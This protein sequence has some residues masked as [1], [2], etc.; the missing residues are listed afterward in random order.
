L[1]GIHFG[2]CPCILHATNRSNLGRPL[3]AVSPELRV[4]ARAHGKGKI[5]GK[6]P[7][8]S[9][10]GFVSEFSERQVSDF[11]FRRIGPA[12][13][14]GKT[15]ADVKA[16]VTKPADGLPGI[17][18]AIEDT[19]NIQPEFPV[20]TVRRKNDARGAREDIDAGVRRL[21]HSAPTSKLGVYTWQS[22]HFGV[23]IRLRG[24]IFTH[25]HGGP[26]ERRGTGTPREA[27]SVGD[28]PQAD[29]RGS[30]G[31]DDPSIR[32]ESRRSRSSRESKPGPRDIRRFDRNVSAREFDGSDPLTINPRVRYASTRWPMTRR[33]QNFHWS[34][35]RDRGRHVIRSVDYRRIRS[36]VLVVTCQCGKNN[37]SD[38]SWWRTELAR[39]ARSRSLDRFRAFEPP[40]PPSPTP[41][42]CE[43][44]IRSRGSLARATPRSAPPVIPASL[45]R[46]ISYYYATSARSPESKMDAFVSVFF[47][48][49]L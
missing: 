11:R 42:S 37:N 4:H 20:A 1:N 35:W 15:R 8:S 32:Q 46:A 12:V 30:S 2:T 45:A 40:S 19:V 44:A 23:S 43:R 13:A 47:A 21:P 36:H 28:A 9:L 18:W 3:K 49:S 39:P 29:W 33:D 7:P 27:R 5:V 10:R 48:F 26:R 41:L 24:F 38:N 6:R 34:R 25:A 22:R 16:T 17:E 14:T 31:F